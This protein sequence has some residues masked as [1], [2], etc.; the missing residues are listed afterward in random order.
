MNLFIYLFHLFYLLT[1]LFIYLFVPLTEK[2]LLMFTLVTLETGVG[3]GSP[4]WGPVTRTH[5]Y[6][7]NRR[8]ASVTGLT[9][10]LRREEP[11]LGHR[12][13]LA[14]GGR[15]RLRGRVRYRARTPASREAMP[16]PGAFLL[17]RP[18]SRA[19][20]QTETQTL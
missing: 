15:E 11:L 9:S 3:G 12:T 10:P 18:P 2:S 1:C 4:P 5:R 19:R 14:G 8:E 20:T 7:A 17:R 13:P 6:A 16:S